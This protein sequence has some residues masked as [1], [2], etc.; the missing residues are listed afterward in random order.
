MTNDP[1][2]GHCY[3]VGVDSAGGDI[4]D[5]PVTSIEGCQSECKRHLDCQLFVYA[6]KDKHCFLK[7]TSGPRSINTDRI[8]GP[9]VC[10]GNF[11]TNWYI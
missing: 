6:S 1:F 7:H 9:R 5:F 8:V 2:L 10:T 3:E 11:Y 4:K